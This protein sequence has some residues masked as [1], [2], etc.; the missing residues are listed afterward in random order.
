MQ[1]ALIMPIDI[2]F[3]I[4]WVC[5]WMYYYAQ[6]KFNKCT[7]RNQLNGF[8]KCYYEETKNEIL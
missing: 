3:Q 8:K 1:C 7:K 4:I 2:R 6:Q 5:P